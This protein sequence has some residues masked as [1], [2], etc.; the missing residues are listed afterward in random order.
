MVSNYSLVN[1]SSK[2]V[3]HHTELWGFP[4]GSN[5]P[6]TSRQIANIMAQ[7]SSYIFCLCMGRSHP[8]CSNQLAQLRS[9]YLLVKRKENL[10][11]GHFCLH[12]HR[13]GTDSE[14]KAARSFFR[15]VRR[16]FFL[17]FLLYSTICLA[18]GGIRS[19]CVCTTIE[20]FLRFLFCFT[21]VI[22]GKLSCMYQII[23]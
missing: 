1:I 9:G 3:R 14:S 6:R 5:F 2:L 12:S 4:L 19:L 16:T 11:S 17:I 7:S 18:E 13:V 8:L 21:C 20:D 23:C 15:Q 22:R 10:A